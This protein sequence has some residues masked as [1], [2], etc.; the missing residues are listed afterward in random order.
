[1]PRFAANLSMMFTER[2]FEDRFAAA[3][4]AGFTAV[5]MLFPYT[6]DPGL[7]AG[8]LRRHGLHLALFNMCPGD[9][10]AGERGLTCLPDKIGEFRAALREGARYVQA[11]R[12]D[13]VHLMAGY[14]PQGAE[15]EDLDRVFVENVRLAARTLAPFGTTVN[16]EAINQVS[17]PGYFLSTQARSA[18][19]VELINEPNVGMQFDC[20]HCQMQ[21]GFVTGR[22]QRYLPLIRHIQIAGAPERHEP[23]TGELRYEY[24]F[25][26]MDRIGYTGYVGCE[27]NP[28]AGTTDGLGWF[29]PYASGKKR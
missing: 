11:L 23:D 29:A 1:M 7:L 15:P 18:G 27:Y 14:A 16:L 28:A 5:E 4:E 3:A 13:C 10:D 20:F 8:L 2:P 26:L 6:Y 19:F 21:E 12:P 9:M 17:M 22:L 25:E 24:V